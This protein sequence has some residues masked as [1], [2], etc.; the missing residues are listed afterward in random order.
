MRACVGEKRKKLLFDLV[1]IF[2]LIAVALSVFL[3]TELFREDG[4]RVVVTVGGERVA[5]DLLSED[6]EYVLGGGTN[7][8]VI[9][10]G[11]AYIKSAT[12]P[13]KTCVTVGGRISRGGER[14]ICLP[15]SL[16]VE[17]LGDEDV[18]VSLGVVLC[19]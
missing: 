7:I 17:I 2:A 19:K 13:D 9:E 6:G 15:N 5:E 1:L 18:L 3:F 11:T 4:K 10:D 14:I 12:C 8:L 16:I